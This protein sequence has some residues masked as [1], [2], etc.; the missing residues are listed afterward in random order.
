MV[1][2]GDDCP[3]IGDLFLPVD[4]TFPYSVMLLMGEHNHPPPPPEKTPTNIKQAIAEAAKCQQP[5]HFNKLTSRERLAALAMIH[6]IDISHPSFAQ[7]Q[8]ARN[9]VPVQSTTPP[10]VHGL[11]DQ[12]ALFQ[13]F[14][15]GST[16]VAGY[17]QNVS[18]DGQ[19][20][21]AFAMPESGAMLLA[22]ARVFDIDMTFQCTRGAV[23][24]V[25]IVVYDTVTNA[26]TTVA[27]AWV[28]RQD[29]DTY[30]AIILALFA[31]Y[32]QHTGHPL[33]FSAFDRV[34]NTS[35]PLAKVG[36][37][38]VVPIDAIRLDLDAGQALGVGQA[39]LSVCPAFGTP[40]LALSHVGVPCHVHFI[41]NVLKSGLSSY[42][43]KLLLSL[44][45][46]WTANDYDDR[47]QELLATPDERADKAEAIVGK[48]SQVLVRSLF[49]GYSNIPQHIMASV[50]PHTNT[51]ESTNERDHKEVGIHL[52]LTEYVISAKKFDDEDHQRVASSAS[53]GVP[54]MFGSSRSARD[55]ANEQRRV[56]SAEKA[57]A[58]SLESVK[59]STSSLP[60]PPTARAKRSRTSVSTPSSASDPSDAKKKR[61]TSLPASTS[62]SVPT[63][64]QPSPT[65]SVPPKALTEDLLAYYAAMSK[66]DISQQVL[67]TEQLLSVKAYRK[68]K[69]DALADW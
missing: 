49:P 45:V 22:R 56:K 46:C 35:A 8:R 7:R 30:C 48:Y 5:S 55:A 51:I 34:N 23:N 4:S 15:S 44:P 1:K 39:L 69:A 43:R 25:K 41:R 14:C 33:H 10:E 40:E 6:R 20:F 50:C 65:T 66:E 18:F 9:L 53:T 59:A 24:M 60:A 2:C 63:R 32:K 54:L 57:R 42:G 52:S 27:R 31:A 36:K 12:I 58:K 47:L 3:V 64:T 11:P 62:S 61:K 37:G 67:T 21:I 19:R 26:A 13:L 68:A 29:A 16:L 28:D 38:L 17:L